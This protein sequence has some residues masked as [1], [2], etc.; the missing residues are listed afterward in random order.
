MPGHRVPSDRYDEVARTRERVMYETIGSPR[1]RD[2]TAVGETINL[3]AHVEKLTRETG[4]GVLITEE[5]YSQAS[6]A[7]EVRPVEGLSLEGIDRPISVYALETLN[8]N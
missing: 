5:T 4:G 2:Y 7:V 1:R 8:Q 3:A 6:E